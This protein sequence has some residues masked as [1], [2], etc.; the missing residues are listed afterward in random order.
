MTH[1]HLADRNTDRR[2]NR[3]PCK[4]LRTVLAA[5]LFGWRKQDASNEDGPKGDNPPNVPMP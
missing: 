1:I 5:G 3:A 2:A 4:P